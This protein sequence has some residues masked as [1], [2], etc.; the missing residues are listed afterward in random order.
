MAFYQSSG[1][2]VE[3]DA[4]MGLRLDPP[5]PDGLPTLHFEGSCA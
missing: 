3:H 4:L 5:G 1:R 2:G